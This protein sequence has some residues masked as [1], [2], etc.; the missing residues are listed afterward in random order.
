MRPFLNYVP[1]RSY[2]QSGE[3]LIMNR[4]LCRM[5]I[6][7]P[8][9]LDIGANDPIKNNNTYLFY[10]K[11]AHGILIEPDPVL[12]ERIMKKRRKDKVLNLGISIEDKN[13]I[14]FYVMTNRFLNTFSYEEAH[15]IQSYGKDKIEKTIKVN[16]ITIDSLIETYCLTTPNLVSLDIE[17]LDFEIL[18]SIN[19]STFR[20][21]VFCIETITYTQDNTESKRQEIFE[22]MK[23]NGYMAFADTYINT[24]FVDIP[25][26]K[27]R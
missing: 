1:N 8:V 22:L 18:K 21:E 25:K 15:K 16:V 10:T 12:Y 13:E 20:P 4:A 6:Q 7:K 14:D 9:Y 24:I 3:D 5:G 2:S 23:H 11:G 19:F 26:W 17:G 27:N